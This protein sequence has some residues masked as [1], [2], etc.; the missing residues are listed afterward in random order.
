MI[1][2]FYSYKVY[3]IYYKII[4]KTYDIPSIKL[5]LIYNNNLS[6]N[7]FLYIMNSN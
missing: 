2:D 6:T 5:V 4:H 1:I 7:N 3:V